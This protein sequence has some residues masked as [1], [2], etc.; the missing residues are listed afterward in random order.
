MAVPAVNIVIDSGTTFETTFTLTNSA[1]GVMDLSDYTAVSKI[2]KY[3]Q[4]SLNIKSFS[5]GIASTAGQITI[6]M[7]STTTSTLEQGRNYYDIVV[8]SPTAVVSKVIEG[9]AIVNPTVS[10]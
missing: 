2:R 1:G 8:T 3:P 7:A 6:S 9:N 5:V 10:S 4:D